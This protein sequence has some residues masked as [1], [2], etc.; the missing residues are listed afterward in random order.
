[1]TIKAGIIGAT[2]YAGLEIVRLLLGHPEVEIAAVSSVSFTGKA[3]SEVYPAM[4]GLMDKTLED[5][6]AVV[7]KCDVVFASLP[8][9]LSEQIASACHGAGKLFIDMGADFRLE[10]EADYKQWYGGEYADKALHERAVYGLPE[11]CREKI[12]S[13]RLIANPGC[14][15]TSIALGLAPLLREKLIDPATLI[16]DAK[17]GVT[18]AGR[19]LSQNTHFPELNESFA[20]YKIAQ[21]RHTP[22]IEQTLSHIS[23]QPVTVTFVPHLLPVNRG[24]LSTM[25]AKAVKGLDAGELEA[26]YRQCYQN[27]KFVRV[28]PGG[29]PASIGQVRYSNYCNIS[30]HTDPRTGRVIVASAIDNMLKGAAG[31]AVQNMN[32][33]CGFAEDTALNLT[34]PA[35]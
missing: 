5:D 24:I 1:M 3:L 29:V 17:S 11:L 35:V 23:G 2:G 14:Y 10:S 8:H 21:H 22:E 15:P 31:Q 7:E 25:Y 33:A 30:L 6:K 13:A 26:L 28:L 27:E 16:I 18:G 32:I 20:P 12:K 19:G 9:G 34:P 4:T